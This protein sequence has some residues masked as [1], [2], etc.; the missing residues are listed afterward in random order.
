MVQD[1]PSPIPI[2]HAAE[3]G[4]VEMRMVSLPLETKPRSFYITSAH[5]LGSAVFGWAVINA[6]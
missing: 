1:E 6:Q 3:K 5:P 4:E 2:S